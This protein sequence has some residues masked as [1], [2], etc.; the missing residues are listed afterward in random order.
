M[1]VSRI[2]DITSFVYK[3][4]LDEIYHICFNGRE[5]LVLYTYPRGVQ[6]RSFGDIDELRRWRGDIADAVE[7]DIRD[8]DE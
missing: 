8:C 4:E 5:F 7:I 6:V 2:E 1:V 3:D